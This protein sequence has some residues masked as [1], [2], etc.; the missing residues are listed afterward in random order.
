[1]ISSGEFPAVHRVAVRVR[2]ARL[3]PHTSPSPQI[4]TRAR[5]AGLSS[6]PL[7][8]LAR[9]TVLVGLA[10]R[11]SPPLGACPRQRAFPARPCARWS[12][13][14]ERPLPVGLAARTSRLAPPRLTPPTTR[15]LNPTIPASNTL[16]SACDPTLEKHMFA[17]D[18]RLASGAVSH[19][20]H[21][22]PAVATPASAA[23]APPVASLP[24][25]ALPPAP[26]SPEQHTAAALSPH[27]VIYL[28]TYEL[29]SPPARC[30]R[31]RVAQS[32]HAPN[33]AGRPFPSTSPSRAV[34]PDSRVRRR[35]QHSRPPLRARLCHCTAPFR[36]GPS[37]QPAIP[38]AAVS[39]TP[40]SSRARESTTRPL[41]VCFARHHARES[42]RQSRSPKPLAS[43][44]RIARVL[45]RRLRTRELH[46]ACPQMH[47][48]RRRKP[49][50]GAPRVQPAPTVARARGDL[51]SPSAAFVWCDAHVRALPR[52]R[53][54]AARPPCGSTP[55]TPPVFA[56]TR[57]RAWGTRRLPHPVPLL[58]PSPVLAFL[59]GTSACSP[60]AAPV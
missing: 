33:C 49:C 31:S 28:P 59:R 1:M 27:P 23:S 36:I 12:C 50:P 15:A 52:A 58:P 18:S 34:H 17:A 9:S 20:G 53:A 42:G 47:A 26:R 38:R 54:Y 43:A 56:S 25:R 46:P 21:S 30:A 57:F 37:T 4:A 5:G 48:I 51:R 22:S 32:L 41:P 7:Q 13:A 6:P 45:R 44:S 60:S 16:R 8:P 2:S 40:L 55:R 29:P 3:A 24:S 35:V 39:P 11:T 10:P 14:D 19:G